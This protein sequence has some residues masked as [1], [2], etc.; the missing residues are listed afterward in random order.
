M[1]PMIAA[2]T[3]VLA[4]GGGFPVVAALTTVLAHG[5][6]DDGALFLLAF[7]PVGIILLVGF[8]IVLRPVVSSTV[9]REEKED[10]EP[11]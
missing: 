9:Q 11:Q 10:D 6:G 3:T 1:V 4:H 5:G 8:V 2:L 7:V